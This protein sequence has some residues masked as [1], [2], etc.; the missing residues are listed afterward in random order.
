MDTRAG[1]GCVLGVLLAACSSSKE[2]GGFDGG[3]PDGS[4]ADSGSGGGH[5]AAAEDGPMI[6]FG[7]DSGDGP[8]GCTGIACNV[9]SCPGGGT[10]T[11]E[12]YVYAP[13]GTLPLYDVQ[14]FVPNAALDTFP[15]GVQCQN[16][17]TPISGAP[18]TT[19]LSDSTGHFKLTG[20]PTG[21]N[22]PLVVQLGKWRRETFIPSVKS[23]VTT[24]LTDP[25]MTRL[26]KNQK[27]G[28]MPHI[29]LTAGGCDH[30]GCMLPKIGI[31][32]A[33]FGFQSDGYNKAVN[34]YNAETGGDSSATAASNL[35]G[36]YSLLSTYDVGIFSCECEEPP[37]APAGSAYYANVTKYLGAGGRIFTTDFMY[38]WYKYSPDP[39]MG[40]T[41]VGSSTIGIG[42][43]IGG[44]PGGGNPVDLVSS[45]PKAL[46]LTQWIKYVFSGKPLPSGATYPFDSDSQIGE[47]QADYVFSNIQSVSATKTVTWATSPSPM[48]PRVFTVDT[49]VGMPTDKQCGRGVHLDIHIDQADGENVGPGYPT[50]GCNTTMKPEEAMFAF[51]FFDLSSCIQNEMTMPEP[52][53]P[54]H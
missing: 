12:G 35:W 33:E 27:E 47:V 11:V 1:I 31:D 9:A 43:I 13:N 44:A 21:T 53:P 54:I 22:I 40:G 32:P 41:P 49:P 16:C 42:E 17:G 25:N 38:T 3:G 8:A 19:A 50:T 2:Q 46:A 52:P 23:C 10:T 45:F 18:I 30:M 15:K 6:H 51:F 7:S 20:V 24:T 29:A 37:E 34:V 28:S 36:D 48:G 26:P 39:N 5:D 4:F 14:V